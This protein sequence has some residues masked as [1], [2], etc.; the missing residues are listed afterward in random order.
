MRLHSVATRWLLLVL[1]AG[2]SPP[3]PPRVNLAT[4]QRTAPP[5]KPLPGA[6]AHVIL[7]SIDG[8]RI[9]ALSAA[10]ATQL[11]ELIRSGMCAEAETI[12]LS[13]TLPAHTSMFTGLD[14]VRHGITWNDSRP[15]T[16]AHPTIFSVA[17]GAG[18]SVALFF[19][20]EKFHL[21]DGAGTNHWVCG[22][23]AAAQP[24]AP[25]GTRPPEDG[26]LVDEFDRAWPVHRFQ[27]T[28][29]HLGGTD[30]AGHRY[31]W[32]GREYLDAVRRAD[33]A[34]RRVIETV[35]SAGKEG[36]TAIIVTSDH[37]GS[38]HGHYHAGKHNLQE[39]LL[40]PW[41]FKGPG[42]QSG[43]VIERAVKIYDTAPTVLALMGLRFTEERDG[44]PVPEVFR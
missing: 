22:P 15:G 19:A 26:D 41:V 37:G 43:G 20:K 18:H 31:G 4:I 24:G 12:R 21:F 27:L 30:A 36:A 14:S 42:I 40:I 23:P 6:V 33:D 32:M 5:L 25:A 9:D 44:R 39:N 17:A 34:V 1:L 10:P 35:R 3:A 38:G 7:I 13:E 8:L 28:F 16:L 2:C 11:T 29:L